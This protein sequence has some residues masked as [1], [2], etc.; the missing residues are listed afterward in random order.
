VAGLIS[1]PPGGR[2]GEHYVVEV[3]DAVVPQL[4]DELAGEEPA[5]A[6]MSVGKGLLVVWGEG[7]QCRFSG[8]GE[9]PAM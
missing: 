3:D 2:L 9:L 1:G 4:A 6:G 5:L 7:L 8:S